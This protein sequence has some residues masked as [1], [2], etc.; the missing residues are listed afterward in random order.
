M[1]RKICEKKIGNITYE[2]KHFKGDNK[3]VIYRLDEEMMKNG[4]VH[5]IPEE[6]IFDNEKD[7]RNYLEKLKKS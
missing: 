7:A 2:S 4:Q 6:A 1:V 3:Y 5:R